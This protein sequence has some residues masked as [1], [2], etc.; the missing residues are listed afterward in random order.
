[1]D[2]RFFNLFNL[3]EA[4]AIALL[5]SPQAALEDASDRYIAA[6]HLINYPSA[7]STAAL[8]RAAQN[9]A[10][11]LD[12][13]IVRR[14]AVE[15]LGR[16]QV[17]DAL[18]CLAACLDDADNYLVENAVW[19]IGE[20]GTANLNIHIDPEILETMAQVLERPDQTYRV[21]IQTLAKLDYAP[22]L[23][24]I[25][26]FVESADAPT[27]SAA[28]AAVCRF[29]GDY[30]SIEQVV[31]LLQNPSVNARRG[32]IQDLIDAR[33][34]AALPDIAQT[35]VS[36]VFRLRALRLLAESGI[37][38][39]EPSHDLRFE[40]LEPLLDQVILDH[41]QSLKLVHNYD[42]LPQLDFAIRELYD[43]DFGRCYLASQTILEHYGEQA[44]A[45]LLAS[46]HAEAYNDY[47]AHYHI[48]RLLGW[49]NYAPAYDLLIEA[50]HNREPQ[51]QKSRMAAAIALGRLGN[52]AAVLDLK[53]VLESRIWDLKYAAL[54]ALN[55]LGDSSGAAVAQA[56]ADWLIQ[57]KAH[58]ML[59][60]PLPR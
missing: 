52:S 22:A 34:Y 14:K 10:P 1:M 57:A 13:R 28:V 50:L 30:R 26:R 23:P 2:K 48:M 24:R 43:T 29:S 25:Q 44:P 33:Y 58:S 9:A 21:V 37:P 17:A 54:M 31:A 45:A 6:A 15:S 51:F 11:D 38:N 36:V 3:S 19:A 40:Q 8:L 20:I 41:P 12:N 35:P 49:L 56:D 46:Y 7:A 59:A 32:S 27:R 47:G 55:Q 4:E 39:G 18:P 53:L 5:D 42:Q 60:A 16:L